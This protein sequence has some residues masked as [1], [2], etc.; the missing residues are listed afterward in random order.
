MITIV[1]EKPPELGSTYHA[2][3]E[4]YGRLNSA[5]SEDPASCIKTDRVGRLGEDDVSVDHVSNLSGEIEKRKRSCC[6]RDMA[7]LA[8][9]AG[10]AANITADGD[11]GVFWRNN[12][13]LLVCEIKGIIVLL[14]CTAI[15]T[16][17]LDDLG[18]IPTAALASHGGP[19]Y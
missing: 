4:K 16:F 18:V 10:L 19:L 2:V 6:V 1:V 13:G 7:G 12:C 3:C 17:R 5:G 14:V 9:F 15:I 11:G 8:N